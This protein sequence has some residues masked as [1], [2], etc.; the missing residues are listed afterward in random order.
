MGRE[1]AFEVAGFAGAKAGTTAAQQD[2]GQPADIHKALH[3]MLAGNCDEASRYLPSL[4]KFECSC[5]SRSADVA[6][7]HNDIASVSGLHPHT[8][9]QM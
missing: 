4:V 6:A 9:S 1:E 7:I 2:L 8:Y 3:A 5:V